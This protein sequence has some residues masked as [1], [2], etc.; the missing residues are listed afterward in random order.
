MFVHENT[1]RFGNEN[2]LFGELLH[3]N[4]IVK[5]EIINK[6]LNFRESRTKKMNPWTPM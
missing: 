4:L 1:S 3:F 5:T 2:K 6:V